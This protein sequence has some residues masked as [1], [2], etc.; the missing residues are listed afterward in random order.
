MHPTVWRRFRE[1][2]ARLTVSG[3]VLEIG[4]EPTPATLL[5]IPELAGLPRIGVNIGYPPQ[6]TALGF[7]LEQLNAN[8]MSHAFAA[9]SFGLVLCNAVLE[10]DKF[11][12]R[13]IDEIRRIT[14]PGGFVVI[15]APGYGDHRLPAGV[16]LDPDRA[17]DALAEATV[18]YTLHD[19]PGDYYRFTEATMRDVFLRNLEVLEIGSVL[20]PPRIIGL[21]RK[22]G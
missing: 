20:M 16:V 4:A 19:A 10:H 18:T 13:S 8:D 12:W 6:T 7:R 2:V 5:A 9:D 14:R 15:G 21:G 11:F 22:P 3:P 17:G 1:V